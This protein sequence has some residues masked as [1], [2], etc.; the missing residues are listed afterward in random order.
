[1]GPYLP[2]IVLTTVLFLLLAAVL[3]VPVYRFLKREEEAAK[4][5]TKESLERQRK[6]REKESNGAPSGRPPR[7]SRN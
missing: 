6:E 7:P 4:Y 5:W 2:I 1:M 3:L